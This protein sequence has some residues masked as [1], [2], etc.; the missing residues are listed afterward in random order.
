MNTGVSLLNILARLLSS[1]I[2]CLGVSLCTTVL[3]AHAQKGTTPDLKSVKIVRL[4]NG[5]NTHHLEYA[6]TVT[7]DGR[8]LYYVSDRPDG[9]GGHDFWMTTKKDRRGTTFTS[10]KNLKGSLNSGLN[11][12]AAAIAPDGRTMYFTA[13]N[14]KDSKGDCDIYEARLDG[15]QWRI[16]RNLQEINST[17]WDSQP[18]ISSDGKTLYFLSNRLGAL[19]GPGDADIYVSTRGPKG[20]W[21]KPR[22]LGAPVNTPRRE[23]SP[24]I[25]PGGKALYFSSAG[26]GGFGGLD[27]FVSR[28]KKDGK[29]GVPENLGQPINTKWDE[30]FITLPAAGDVIYFSSERDTMQH[31]MLDLYMG[32]LPD[33]EPTI[34]VSGREFDS[35]TGQGI[36]AQLIFIDSATGKPIFGATT[37]P[38]TGEYSLVVNAGEM[39]SVQVYGMCNSDCG[40]DRMITETI[41]LPTAIYYAEV[42]SNLPLTATTGPASNSKH[43]APAEQHT[44]RFTLFPNPASDAI[45]VDCSGPEWAGETKQLD[46]LD[47]YGNQIFSAS[48]TEPRYR[49]DLRDF[50]AG[51]YLARIGIS[52]S[53][54]TVKR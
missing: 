53:P 34:L 27:F 22:N 4:G 42:E 16:V 52:A 17:E 23:D 18:S 20:I 35:L 24:F 13:C 54:F 40:P 32:I 39:S 51:I 19:G 43:V 26:H 6:P 10:P 29:W 44:R 48:F 47:A 33:R 37:D 5:I 14:R 3:P 7:P 49:I 1:G 21:S 38:T 8:T 28:L 31:A 9:K 36:D 50:S 41:D 46:V 11:E 30:R 2:V 12:G 15:D 25:L 45:T